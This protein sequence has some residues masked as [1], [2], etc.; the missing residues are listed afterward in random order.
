VWHKLEGLCNTNESY[1]INMNVILSGRYVA[2]ATGRGVVAVYDVAN[3]KR[4][5]NNICDVVTSESDLFIHAAD[6]AGGVAYLHSCEQPD[7][8]F[9]ASSAAENATS[10]VSPLLLP[11]VQVIHGSNRSM[12]NWL[13]LNGVVATMDT[14]R[15]EL[16]EMVG[17]VMG[18][19]SFTTSQ[20]LIPSSPVKDIK[21]AW[22]YPT[23]L[24]CS[25]FIESQRILLFGG[26]DGLVRMMGLKDFVPEMNRF[27]ERD[28]DFFMSSY[29]QTIQ[30]FTGELS[31]STRGLAQQID[32]TSPEFVAAEADGPAPLDAAERE[33]VFF[34]AAPLEDEEVDDPNNDDSFEN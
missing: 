15:F 5:M 2:V 32:V 34:N 19:D 8:H 17:N 21:L 20:F 14:P 7:G 28:I 3:D 30:Q 25:E 10:I 12:R 16:I 11:W 4:N 33:S 24:C 29:F 27:Q 31:N 18:S 13:G 22:R 9:D 26:T 6:Q 23:V 1:I